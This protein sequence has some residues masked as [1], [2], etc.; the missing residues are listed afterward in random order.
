MLYCNEENGIYS[1]IG[2]LMYNY[3]TGEVVEISD[4]RLVVDVA[5]I[6]YDMMISNTAL[7]EISMGS[8]VKIYTR[9]IVKEDEFSLCG[10]L[11]EKERVLFDFLVSVS[12]VGKKLAMSMLS[13]LSYMQIISFI[14]E[15]DV[16]SLTQLKGV[17]KRTAERL[18]VE[19][20]DKFKKT[21]GNS[22]IVAAEDEKP[23][24]T[25]YAEEIVLALSGLG[26]SSREISKMLDGMPQGASV[27]EAIRYALKNRGK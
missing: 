7:S 23:L 1:G 10:F 27:E 9:L 15:G 6:G 8:V 21:Y 22:L 17:G 12:G 25:S 5:G 20:T 16:K 2:V 11:D 19:L 18:C 4:E 26:F 14:V 24:E 13:S 3:L